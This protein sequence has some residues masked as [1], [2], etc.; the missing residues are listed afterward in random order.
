MNNNRK[1]VVAVAVSVIV[2]GAGFSGSAS[3]AALQFEWSGF[4][5]LPDSAGALI[6]ND[7]VSS[8]PGNPAN[9]LLTPVSGTLTYD[10]S[11]GTGSMTM[12]P[13]EFF[14]GSLPLQAQDISLVDID[15]PGGDT[16]VLGNMLWDW[17]GTE[18]TP[19][20]LVWDIAGLQTAIDAGLTNGEVVSGI[21][22][23]PAIDGTYVGT[24]IHVSTH[25]VVGPG[26]LDGYLEL[27]PS[28]IA[29]TT[30]N[31]SLAPGCT[32]GVDGNYIDNTGGGCMGV[33]PSG[34]LPLVLDTAPNTFDSTPGN[35]GIGGSPML[36]GPFQGSNF[37]VNVTSLTV[38]A[39]PVPAAVWLFGSGLLGLMGMAR[40]RRGS[41]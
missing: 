27:G 19:A 11:A 29:T 16:L 8:S 15:G 33:N 28:P 3:A 31:T 35:Q 23:A 26:G 4:F 20:S 17:N 38:T 41:R 1:K 9:F 14:S 40:R 21:G 30:W 12:A 18:G 10:A 34:V 7:S 6:A 22:S 36:D 25:T 5:S 32:L 13:F 2:G 39:V 37:N 24:G